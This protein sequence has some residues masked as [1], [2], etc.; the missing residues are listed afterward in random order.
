MFNLKVEESNISFLTG[1]VSEAILVVL[2]AHMKPLIWVCFAQLTPDFPSPPV[3]FPSSSL[4]A[5]KYFVL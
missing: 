4:D 2:C 1:S 3:L 5:R